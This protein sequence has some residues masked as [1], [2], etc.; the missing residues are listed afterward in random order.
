MLAAPT[1][2]QAAF[3]SAVAISPPGPDGAA[4]D[5]AI[6]SGGNAVVV[7]QRNDG[8]TGCGGA[9]CH[10]IEARRR[11]A[12]GALGAIQV[13]SPPGRDATGPRVGVDS[14]GNAVFV[15]RMSPPGCELS[16]CGLIQ[17]RALSAAG[18]LSAIQNLT[19]AGQVSE[20][21]VAVDPAGNAVFVWSREDGS[22]GCC[23]YRVESRR[24][25]AAGALSATQIVSAPSQ[26]TSLDAHVKV[27]AE[28]NAIFVW[29]RNIASTAC[30]GTS[31]IRIESRAR[32]ASG[33]LS[34]VQLLSTPGQVAIDPQMALNP[35]GKAV[36]T[37]RAAFG[38]CFRVQGRA[39]STAGVLSA[40]QTLSGPNADSPHAAIDS[41]GNAVFAWARKDDTTDCYD[42]EGAPMGCFRVESGAR[43]AGGVL[44]AVQVLSAPGG[45]AAWPLGHLRV[46]MDAPGN[47]VFAWARED[48]STGCDGVGACDRTQVRYSLPGGSLSAT[49]TL[50]G[51]PAF[52]VALS[53]D[54]N[55]GRD[56]DIADAVAGWSR[57]DGTGYRVEIAVQR[58][59][60]PS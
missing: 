15:W 25:S 29:S 3:S 59:P 13:L 26:Q 49:E 56:P 53:V 46:A 7:W 27:D 33:V 30:G 51:R 42:N 45:H 10:S 22:A 1:A 55:G 38:C 5:V 60:P 54:P 19:T 52:G 57:P 48:G 41:A 4:P 37:W 35:G 18:A 16:S 39:R 44:S 12:G 20:Q 23:S 58:V 50:S 21:E 36:F 6:G 17:A 40:I 8:T 47:V 28:G 43:S 32:S 11:F 24:R 14:K 9:G 31:C 34:A 2:A